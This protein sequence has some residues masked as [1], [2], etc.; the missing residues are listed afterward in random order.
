M[1]NEDTGLRVRRPAV[2]QPLEHHPTKQVEKPARLGVRPR[3]AKAT[4]GTMMRGHVRPLDI[5][6]LIR[7]DANGT[8]IAHAERRS[9]AKGSVRTIIPS[10][11]DSIDTQSAVRAP[12]FPTG[13]DWI[14]TGGRALTLADLRGKIALLDF[15]TYG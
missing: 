8:L 9:E 12:E 3:V 4:P 10:M 13:L 5:H 11:T 14:N 2:R 7:H 6:R 15:W 1:P